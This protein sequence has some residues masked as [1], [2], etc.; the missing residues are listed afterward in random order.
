MNIKLFDS[1][2]VFG[3]LNKQR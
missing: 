2:R 3:F 1:H